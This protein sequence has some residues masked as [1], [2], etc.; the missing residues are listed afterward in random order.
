MNKIN[1][2]VLLVCRKNNTFLLGKRSEFLPFG[3]C[4]SLFGGGIDEN[5]E[6]IDGVKRELMEE[7][8]I[9]SKNIDYELL[10]VQ[11]HLKIPYYFYIGYC[12]KEYKVKLNNENSDFGWFSMGT[13]PEPLFPTLKN[14]LKRIF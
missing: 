13:L 7:T 3:G 4:W 11:H 14:T 6:I 12:D 10:E 2:G 5:E 8:K 1:G 9:D